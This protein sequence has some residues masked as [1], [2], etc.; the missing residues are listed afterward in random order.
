[1]QLDRLAVNKVYGRSATLN[2][3]AVDR[4]LAVLSGIAE[5]A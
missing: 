4:D 5:W 1:V 2:R 3:R